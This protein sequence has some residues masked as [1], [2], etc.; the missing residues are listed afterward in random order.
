MP[1]PHVTS[2]VLR[3]CDTD[4]N[5]HVNNA[6]YA[7]MCEAG[8]AELALR[9]GLIAPERGLAV[10]IARLE[11]DFLREMNWP[12]EIRIETQVTR[13]GTRSF[14]LGQ[15][16]LQGDALV[17]TSLSVLAVIDTESR[18]ALPLTE[19]WRAALAPYTVATA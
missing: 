10:V 8:R 6:V 1:A 9:C 19:T 3:F 17:A 11:L 13:I 18:R 12:G 4:A 14:T 5:G 16:L 15:R 2:Q 7:V